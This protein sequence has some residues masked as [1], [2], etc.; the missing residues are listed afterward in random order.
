MNHDR[1]RGISQHS[2]NFNHHSPRTNSKLRPSGLGHFYQPS[3]S[4]SS[5]ASVIF[6]KTLPTIESNV[7]STPPKIRAQDPQGQAP[8]TA[9]SGLPTASRS[10][11]WLPVHGS[12]SYSRGA[13]CQTL[14]QHRTTIT[15]ELNKNEDDALSFRVRHHDTIQAPI[16]YSST[17][18]LSRINFF[19]LNTRSHRKKKLVISGVGAGDTQK[20]EGI[21]RWYEVYVFSSI[22]FL[23]F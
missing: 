20:F 18:S 1:D 22:F 5:V 9:A 2:A 4:Q 11:I 23:N 15:P 13:H 16:P 10:F 21:K 19:S 8:S 14:S 6:S 7:L 17:G 3:V 12:D